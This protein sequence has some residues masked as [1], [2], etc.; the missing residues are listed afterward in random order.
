MELIE[1]IISNLDNNLVTTGVFIDLKKTFDIKVH[2]ILIKKLCHYCV[3]GIASSWMKMYLT[4]RKQF[5]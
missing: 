5:Y 2:S 1:V 4:N 3:R